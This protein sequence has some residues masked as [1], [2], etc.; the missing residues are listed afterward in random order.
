MYFS[1][2]RYF[3]NV[4]LHFEPIGFSY[5]LKNDLR[6]S[7]EAESPLAASQQEWAKSLFHEALEK[8]RKQQ[9]TKKKS[10]MAQVDDLPRYVTPGT[11]QELR[12]K[13]NFIYQREPKKP[14]KVQMTAYV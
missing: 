14:R 11:D 12:W 13:Q 1:T 2:C 3:A 4:F 6:K 7:E 8:Q 5:E 10:M 9:L